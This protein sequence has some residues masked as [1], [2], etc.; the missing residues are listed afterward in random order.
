MVQDGIPMETVPLPQDKR[1]PWPSLE[2]IKKQQ[3]GLFAYI[4]IGNRVRLYI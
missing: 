1:R 3:I 2:N 4:R